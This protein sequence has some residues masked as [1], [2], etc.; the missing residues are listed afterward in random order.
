MELLS[1]MVDGGAAAVLGGVHA[2]NVC[3]WCVLSQ[4][5][6]AASMMAKANVNEKSMKSVEIQKAEVESD[7]KKM[8]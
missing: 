2:V 8:S 5:Q 7:G 1:G 6:N 3:C 4:L